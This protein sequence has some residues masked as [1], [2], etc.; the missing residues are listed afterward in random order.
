MYSTVSPRIAAVS[1]AVPKY[2]FSQEIAAEYAEKWL[3]CGNGCIPELSVPKAIQVYR[4]SGVDKRYGVT[5]VNELLLE[6]DL[7][8]RNSLYSEYAKWLGEKALREVFKKCDLFPQDVDYFIT[9]SCTGFMIPALDAYLIN[10]F[11]FRKDVKRLPVTQLGCAGG[12][13]SM[14]LAAD[15]IKA[16]PGSTVLIL[17]IELCTLSFQPG[18]KSADHIISTAIFGDGGA[19][20]LI[21]GRRGS[22]I[23]LLRA[24]SSF[25]RQTLDFMGFDLKNSGFHIFLSPGIPRYLRRNLYQEV[26]PILNTMG[27]SSAD[28]DAWLFHPGGMR[29]LE[30]I[31]ESLCI[32]EDKI[33]HSRHILRNYGNL[34]SATIFFIIDEYINKNTGGD[35]SYQVTGA[36]G[37][38]FQLYMIFMKW[39]ELDNQ[40]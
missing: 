22:G 32:D 18:D 21:T 38:G 19:A 6:K 10:K 2:A 15:Y 26:E 11:P 34:S 37:P 36:V 9:V 12:V 1:R 25:F 24:E 8:Y 40:I 4:N 3:S 29:I 31:K 27:I 14:M 5:P 17:S 23:H 20:M 39:L 35:D 28:I 16:Y 7:E 33:F 13:A 30:A